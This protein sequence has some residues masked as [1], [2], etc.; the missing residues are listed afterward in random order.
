MRELRA[1]ALAHANINPL[2]DKKMKELN[3]KGDNGLKIAFA[4]LAFLLVSSVVMALSGSTGNAVIA[5][6]D[7]NANYGDLSQYE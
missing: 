4:V 5:P 6:S 1:L 7:W 3:L 2:R